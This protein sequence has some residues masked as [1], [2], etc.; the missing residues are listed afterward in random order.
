MS[1]F[2]PITH[3]PFRF[4]DKLSGKWVHARYKAT[5]DE[6]AARYAEWEITGPPEVR[7]SSGGAYFN[8]AR[9]LRATELLEGLERE[10]QLSEGERFLVLLFLRRYVTFC[11]RKRS[12]AR[13]RNAARLFRRIELAG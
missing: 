5:R 12:W 6:I 7:E 13:M 4:R 8:P 10:P 9:T 1:L 11:A 3:Y 2:S